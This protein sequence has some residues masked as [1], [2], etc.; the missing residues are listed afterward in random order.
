[1]VTK[2]PVH[3]QVKFSGGR[4]LGN[5]EVVAWWV[6]GGLRTWACPDS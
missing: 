5:E 2:K 1:M 6:N 3:A 4:E